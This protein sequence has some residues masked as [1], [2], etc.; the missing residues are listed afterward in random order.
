TSVTGV[1]TSFTTELRVGDRI[2]V[3]GETR[4]VTAIASNTA[5]TVDVAFSDTANDASVDV[6]Y[7]LASFR[8]NANATVAA[9]NDLGYLGLGNGGSAL[10]PLTVYPTN[11]P[12]TDV[13][14]LS[15]YSIVLSRLSDS[16]SQ[17]PGIAFGSSTGNS[18]V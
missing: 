12:Q 3:S 11:I 17:G 1:G 4:T 18:N 9:I 14:E 7:S 5:L 16:A 13:G 2:T 6:L 10:G 15:N 8:T